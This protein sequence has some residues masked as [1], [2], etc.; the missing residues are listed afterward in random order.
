MV[1]EKVLLAT[2]VVVD[3]GIKR[4]NKAKQNKQTVKGLYPKN[5]SLSLTAVDKSTI[6]HSIWNEVPIQG[7][8]NF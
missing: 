3:V 4:G 1:L 5:T 8:N 2:L 7:H 6:K